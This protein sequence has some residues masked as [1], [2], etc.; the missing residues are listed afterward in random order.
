MCASEA[1]CMGIEFPVV[2]YM[3]DTSILSIDFQYLFFC[4]KIFSIFICIDSFPL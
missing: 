2:I 4:E 1:S 3:P